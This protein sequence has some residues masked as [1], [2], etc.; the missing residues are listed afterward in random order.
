MFIADFK[1]AIRPQYT[2]FSELIFHRAEPQC[3]IAVSPCTA[4]PGYP[5]QTY[6][7]DTSA[8]CT[9]TTSSYTLTLTPSQDTTTSSYEV[10]ANTI[11]CNGVPV[12]HGRI[13]GT[14]TLAALVTQLNQLVGVL[15]VWAVSSSN[16]TLKGLCAT[17]TVPWITQ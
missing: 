9:N 7:S 15:G 14:T 6:A 5:T 13:T 12:E 16:I 2:E 3:I 1:M 11:M 10:E 8:S 17:V 4:D